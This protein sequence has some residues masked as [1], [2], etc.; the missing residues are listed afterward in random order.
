M[1][2]SERN[3]HNAKFGQ[4]PRKNLRRG[5]PDWERSLLFLNNAISDL[6]FFVSKNAPPQKIT[7]PKKYL[8]NCA[9]TTN[10]S[11]SKIVPVRNCMDST[12]WL[13]EIRT[14]LPIPLYGPVHNCMEMSVRLYRT[15]RNSSIRMYRYVRTLYGLYKL[16]GHK[17]FENLKNCFFS[18]NVQILEICAET[19]SSRKL[20]RKFVFGLHSSWQACPISLSLQ[21]TFSCQEIVFS[22]SLNETL[23]HYKSFSQWFFSN[24]LPNEWSI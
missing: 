19:A 21:I 23:S 8:E 13:Y 10:W 18:Q 15:V 17:I 6:Q 5:K 11:A 3:K 1:K 20:C 2:Q 24:A 7:E 4:W 14:D 9:R 12:V 16:Y 22:F